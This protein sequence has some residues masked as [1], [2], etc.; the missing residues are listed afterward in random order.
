MKNRI[1][2]ILRYSAY[3]LIILSHANILKVVQATKNTHLR[4]LCDAC[5]HNEPQ[6]GIRIF[7]NRKERPKNL[8]IMLLERKTILIFYVVIAQSVQKRLIVLINKNHNTSIE[9]FIGRYYQMI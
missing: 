5:E 8:T 9:L 2:F 6:I 7:E 1:Q 4:E 3:S